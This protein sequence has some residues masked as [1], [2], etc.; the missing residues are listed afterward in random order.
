MPL[1]YKQMS[2]FASMGRNTS[3]RTQSL[4]W[5]VVV[6]L[7]RNRAQGSRWCIRTWFYRVGITDREKKE[8]YLQMNYGPFYCFQ[9]NMGLTELLTMSP[10][11]WSLQKTCLHL[12]AFV[13]VMFASALGRGEQ[14]S[15][16]SILNLD[17]RAVRMVWGKPELRALSFIIPVSNPSVSIMSDVVTYS[18]VQSALCRA[19]IPRVGSL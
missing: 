14:D 12:C 7:P 17:V 19:W 15:W 4:R 13:Y 16:G 1:D 2:T 8:H 6:F 5:G 9:G 3:C 11:S 10:L 18:T